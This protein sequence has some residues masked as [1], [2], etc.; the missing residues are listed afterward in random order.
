MERMEH[1]RDVVV[2]VTRNLYRGHHASLHNPMM[3]NIYF[4]GSFCI[5]EKMEFGSWCEVM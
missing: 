4:Q 1:Y 2:M 5:T 3:D